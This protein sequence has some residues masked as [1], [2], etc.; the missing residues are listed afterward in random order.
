MH[1][2]TALPVLFQSQ[3]EAAFARREDQT[4]ARMLRETD[5]CQFERFER[6]YYLALDAHHARGSVR[7]RVPEV[8]PESRREAQVRTLVDI[9]GK[10]RP[11]EMFVKIPVFDPAQ[12]LP[13]VST[14]LAGPG[15]P[16]M[17]FLCMLRAFLGVIALG[18]P[19]SPEAVHRELHS[20][21][22]FARLCGFRCSTRADRAADGPTARHLPSLS[23]CGKFDEVMTASGLWAALR[24]DQVRHNLETGVVPLGTMLAFDTAHA[25]A[26][27]ACDRVEADVAPGQTERRNIP[28]LHKRCPCPVSTWETCPHPWEFTDPGAA[29]VVKNRTNIHW[30][31]KASVAG[32]ADPDLEI[33]LDIRVATY[34]ATGDGDTLEPHLREL[35][36]RFPEIVGAVLVVLADGAYRSGHNQQAV[37]SLLPGATLHVPAPSHKTPQAVI[38]RHPGIEKFTPTGAPV[39]VAGHRFELVGRD[40]IGQLY[41]WKAPDG[42]DGRPVCAD[43]PLRP[44]CGRGRGQRRTLRTRRV[45]FPQIDWDH[46]QHLD[47][48]RRLI[49]RRTSIERMIK[50]IK[51]DLHGETLTRRHARRV[52]AHFDKRL[53]VLHLLLDDTS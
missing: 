14:M 24:L 5:W 6:H 20:N 35:V 45:D 25:D 16:P 15:R 49:R 29:V 11:P 53:L 8:G 13:A 52:Q 31:H 50:R 48:H 44:C 4:W 17:D 22:T 32:F 33:P 39:C 46:P 47:R 10:R 9:V 27:S 40:V 38:D 1:Q 37:A 51:V 36:D 28:R 30:A 3:D 34:A 41:C 12:V 26:Y 7:K 18:W 42:E 23:M 21:P 2:D 43:C 19:E